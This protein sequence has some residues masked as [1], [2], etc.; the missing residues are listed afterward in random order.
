MRRFEIHGLHRSMHLFFQPIRDHGNLTIQDIFDIGQIL[1]IVFLGLVTFAR[2]LAIADLIFQTDLVLP[3][4]N[5][6]WGKVQV[7]G[8]QWKEFA[9]HVQDDVHHPDR[10]IRTVILGSILDV[11]AGPEYSRKM[12]LFD[13]N[14]RIGLIILE[15]HI[16]AGLVFFDQVVFQQPGID[17]RIHDGESDPVDLAHQHTGLAIQLGLV[18]KIGTYPIP[19]ILCLTDIDQRIVLIKILIN[20]RFVWDFRQFFPVI[21]FHHSKKNQTNLGV[22][23]VW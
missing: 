16:V 10:S 23:L 9:D 11:L 4:G 8:T 6:L 12:L 1:I 3:F 7:T 20:P 19:Q 5:I 2:P 22:D 18:Y 14:P 15:H 13:D 17:L 21:K